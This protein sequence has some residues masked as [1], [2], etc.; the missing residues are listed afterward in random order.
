[1]LSANCAES[2]DAFV[3]QLVEYQTFNLGVVGSSPTG[4]T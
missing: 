1:M 4:G 2:S 3:T